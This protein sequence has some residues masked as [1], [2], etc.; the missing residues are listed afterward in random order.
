MLV[1]DVEKALGAV[2]MRIRDFF[3][4]AALAGGPN[5]LSRT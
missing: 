4:L 5:S 3:V 1:E 2:G